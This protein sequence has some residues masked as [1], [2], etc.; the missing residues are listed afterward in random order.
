MNLG[1]AQNKSRL[2]IIK[3]MIDLNLI[4]IKEISNTHYL[5]EAITL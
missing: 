5:S 2:C 4:S 3:K 1:T